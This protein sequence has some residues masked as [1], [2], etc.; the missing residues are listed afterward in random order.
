MPPETD[1]DAAAQTFPAD[2]LDAFEDAQRR[3]IALL[4]T[5]PGASR[6]G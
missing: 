6:P 2:V 4:G 1:T 5:P 3:T